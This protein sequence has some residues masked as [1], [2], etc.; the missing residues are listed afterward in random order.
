MAKKCEHNWWLFTKGTSFQKCCQAHARNT[1]LKGH[2]WLKQPL[3]RSGRVLTALVTHMFAVLTPH[4]SH[5]PG[6]DDKVSHLGLFLFWGFH[7]KELPSNWTPSLHLSIWHN[8]HRRH[9]WPP[10]SGTLRNFLTNAYSYARSITYRK[11]RGWAGVGS[12]IQ[13]VSVF[14]KKNK[15]FWEVCSSSPEGSAF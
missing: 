2:V 14:M 9:V 5:P 8:G 10:Y 13:Q 12:E 1:H 6:V 11:I 3:W 15:S 7:W 4:E